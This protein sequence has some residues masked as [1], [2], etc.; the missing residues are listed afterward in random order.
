MNH[1][2]RR[3]YAVV[4]GT[5]SVLS[6]A[7]TTMISWILVMLL[8]LPAA[9]AQAADIRMEV[10]DSAAD[11]C[12]RIADPHPL[13][14]VAA[15]SFGDIESGSCAQKFLIVTNLRSHA[16]KIRERIHGKNPADFDPGVY[17]IG[18]ALLCPNV[19]N[20]TYAV[21]ECFEVG[22]LEADHICVMALNFC[23]LAA[24]DRSARLKVFG[25]GSRDL[26]L[27]LSGNGSGP[28]GP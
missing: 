23:P 2:G 18:Y 19:Q 16:L 25:N 6:A 4:F 21:P 11:V 27:L 17:D 7:A 28:F 14:K 12:T 15:V 10:A 8:T 3:F 1:R 24:G 13:P 22:A 20:P 26:L 9:T 5:M